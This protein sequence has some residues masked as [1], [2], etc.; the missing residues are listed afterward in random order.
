MALAAAKRDAAEKGSQVFVSSR[1]LIEDYQVTSDMVESGVKARILGFEVLENG[2]MGETGYRYLIKARVTPDFT[3]NQS[4]S[5]DTI[6]VAGKA[7]PTWIFSPRA[8]RDSFAASACIPA[9]GSMNLD[10]RIASANAR[11]ELAQTLMTTVIAMDESIESM[12]DMLTPASYTSTT[13]SLAAQSLR[14]SSVAQAGYYE[15]DQV[16][17]FC[18]LVTMP[19]GGGRD[20]FEGIMAAANLTGSEQENTLY[21]SFLDG[22]I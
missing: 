6:T 5:E 7:L 21:E 19:E 10:R 8:P 15:I 22:E 17:H 2:L 12:Q 20:L 9:T 3:A 11:A 13:R 14:G 4:D 1:T 18:A 16:R